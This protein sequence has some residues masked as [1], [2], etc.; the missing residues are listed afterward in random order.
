[1]ST[2]KKQLLMGICVVI[3]I[4]VFSV[5]GLHKI[6][7]EKQSI[8]GN[9]NSVERKVTVAEAYRMFSYFDYNQSEREALPMEISYSSVTMSDWYDTYVN[10]VYHMGLINKKVEVSPKEVLTYT[11]GKTL[12]DKM[13][14]LH[15]KLKGVYNKLS[16]Q[17]KPSE[18]DLPENEFLELYDE[19]V[20][21]LSQEDGRVREDKLFILGSQDSSKGNL[22]LITDQGE[23][24]CEYTINYAKSNTVTTTEQPYRV[25]GQEIATKYL[26]KALK[27]YLCDQ[28]IICILGEDSRKTILTNVWIIQEDDNQVST[29]IC[30]I[31]R[32]FEADNLSLKD[33]KKI[34]ADIMI[35]NKKVIEVVEKSEMIQGKVLQSGEDYIEIEGYGKVSLQK[36]YK[37]Y[38]T[39]GELSEEPIESVLVGYDN[40]SFVLSDGEI[41]AA[42]IIESIHADNIRVLIKTT[43]FADR[44]HETVTLTAT[45]DFVISSKRKKTSYDKGEIVTIQ[46]NDQVLSDGRITVKAKSETGRIE[47]QSIARSTGNPKYHGSIEI[48]EGEEGLLLINELPME[49]YLYSVIPSEMPT[50]YGLESLKVQAVCARS[51]AYQQLLNNS[52][53]RYGAHVDDSVTYQVYNNIAEEENSVKAVQETYGEVLEYKGEVITA[54]YFSTS[55]GHTAGVKG[56]WATEEDCPYLEGKLLSIEHNKVSTNNQEEEEKKIQVYEENMNIYQ[57]LSSEKVFR[58][59]LSDENVITYD[60]KSNW[61]RW[62]VTIDLLDLEKII[63]QNLKSRYEANPQFIQMMTNEKNEAG[64]AVF[65]SIPVDTVGSIV[66]I[67]VLKR[68]QSGVISELLIAGSEHTIKVITEYNIRTLLSPAYDDVVRQDDS[69][70][71]G[72]NLLPSAYCVINKITED[73]SSSII[74]SGGG[75]GHGVGMSQN[76]VKEMADLGMEY[77]EIATYFYEGSR[78]GFIYE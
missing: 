62:N 46:P 42:L 36:N 76:G 78:M 68:E 45:S 44:Y 26:D 50:Y 18:A 52:L 51:Y 55:C 77:E 61:Y 60:N 74:I 3:I 33:N 67:S 2:K 6:N 17:L 73:D 24:T 35:E 65:E 64:E 27:T 10:A 13:I 69:K 11:V 37:I 20:T 1:M 54:Y 9:D 29:F 31:Y 19:I 21:V 22:D 58:R 70:V 56:V 39:Y 38:K 34:V 16:F 32:E 71:S 30:G 28:E 57:N 72:L 12:I 4:T 49:E 40:T 59:F 43:D 53:N 66:D 23:Y 25:K 63:N 75:F 15:P 47:I 48:A 7:I 14:L 8:T 41:C 5:N